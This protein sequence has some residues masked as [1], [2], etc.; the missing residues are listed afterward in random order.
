VFPVHWFSGHSKAADAKATQVRIKKIEKV[1][2][3]GKVKSHTKTSLLF[4][5]C[6]NLTELKQ[7]LGHSHCLRDQCGVS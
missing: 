6:I 3:P 5:A 1:E 7:R 2:T 4:V